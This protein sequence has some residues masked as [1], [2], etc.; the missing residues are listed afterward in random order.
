[1]VFM[2]DGFLFWCIYFSSHFGVRHKIGEAVLDPVVHV[3][4]KYVEWHCPSRPLTGHVLSA[5]LYFLLFKTCIYKNVLQNQVNSVI[6][7]KACFVVLIEI[8]EIN[9]WR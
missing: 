1:M 9:L 7:L 8:I 4:Y 2:R 6:V 3:I 5:H